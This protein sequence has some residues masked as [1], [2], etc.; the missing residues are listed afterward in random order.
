[1]FTTDLPDADGSGAAFE[2][3]LGGQTG[4]T[5]LT[6]PRA[7]CFVQRPETVDRHAGRRHRVKFEEA[8]P[9]D[10]APVSVG[11]AGHEVKLRGPHQACD[12]PWCRAHQILRHT[13][14]SCSLVLEKFCL[15]NLYAPSNQI[16]IV[17]CIR[18]IAPHYGM[19]LENRWMGVTC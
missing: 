4:K 3:A 14:A 7:G 6:G 8:G 9:T 15:S 19:Q 17:I 11:R 16:I 5:L 10:P 2:G 12:R 1:M 13:G 18:N